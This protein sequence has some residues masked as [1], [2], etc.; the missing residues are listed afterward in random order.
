[1]SVADPAW[2]FSADNLTLEERFGY[3]R[4]VWPRA[5]D[6][7]QLRPGMRVLDVGCGSGSFTRF[8]AG[9][10]EGRGEVVGVD[11]DPDLLAKARE[12][13]P[14][15]PALRARFEM[16]DVHKLPFADGEF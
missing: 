7:L 3:E 5:R 13:M 11:T 15:T 4:Q 8:V 9:A 10:L 1:M 12:A 14:S 6:A 2:R 16:G